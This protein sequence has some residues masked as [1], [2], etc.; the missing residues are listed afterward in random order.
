MSITVR[1]S[2]IGR[3]GVII[4]MNASMTTRQDESIVA[5]IWNLS[6]CMQCNYG[7]VEVWLKV[8]DVIHR[9]ALVMYC[10][11]VQLRTELLSDIVSLISMMLC[12]LYARSP[13]DMMKDGYGKLARRGSRSL[14]DY[15]VCDG[16]DMFVEKVTNEGF[17]PFQDYKPTPKGGSIAPYDGYQHRQ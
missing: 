6:N 4:P 11:N 8:V 5:F 3:D 12:E 10:L 2:E 16:R 7:K 15:D 17:F 13:F 14:Y 9:S 1:L